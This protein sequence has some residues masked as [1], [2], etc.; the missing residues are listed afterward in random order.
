MSQCLIILSCLLAGEF[1]VFLFLSPVCVCVCLCLCLCLRERERERERE[2]VAALSS[3]PLLS[4][5]F[6][7]GNQ[8]MRV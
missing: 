1:I 4:V 7:Q 3:F 2:R 6:V 5:L 8:G